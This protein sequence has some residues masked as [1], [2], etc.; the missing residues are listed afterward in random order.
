VQAIN[1]LL[2]VEHEIPLSPLSIDG[3]RIDE[4]RIDPMVVAMLM[5]ILDA[6]PKSMVETSP[7]LVM[8]AGNGRRT[9]RAGA[10]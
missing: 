10:T 6:E 8:A 3:L 4:N 5:P 1:Q 9:A 7:A 2:A